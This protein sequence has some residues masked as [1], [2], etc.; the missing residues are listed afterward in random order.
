MTASLFHPFST[1]ALFAALLVC[2]L[3][4]QPLLA[5]QSKANAQDEPA[6]S[7]ESSDTQENADKENKNAGEADLDEAVIKRIDAKTIDQLESIGALLK[8]AISKGLD[9][10]NESFAKKMLASVLLERSQSLAASMIQARGRRALQLRDEIL[11][12]LDEAVEYDPTLVEAHL[13]IA[14]L[15]LL[16][17][18]DKQAI[19]EAT[20]NAIKL[21]KDDPIEMS[22]ALVLRAMTQDD[23]DK[24]LADLDAAIEADPNNMAAYQERAAMRLQQDD[25]E[26]AIEDLQI[27]LLKEPTNAEVAATVVQK[28]AELDRVDDAIE[29]ITKT[30]SSQPSEGLYRLRADL[31]RMEEKYDEALSDLNKAYAMQPED[32]RTLL[33]RAGLALERE[34]VKSAKQD[35]QSALRIQPAII[36]L[37]LAVALRAQIAMQENRLADAINDLKLLVERSPR[38]PFRRMQ[39]AN[40]YL[41]DK[42]PRKA[43]D[44]MSE[45]LD[46]DPKNMLALRSRGDTLLSVGDHAAAIE[47][48]EKALEIIGNL[49]LTDASPEQK[50]EAAAVYNNLSWV[51]STSPNDSVRDGQRAV[52]LGKK[53]AELSDFK[54]A[55]IL[56]T[57]AA[58]YAEVGNFDKAIEWSTKAV[59]LGREEEHAQLEQLEQELESYQQGKPWR[60]KQESEE[61]PVP[62]LSPEDLIDT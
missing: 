21:L 52:E 13:M 12:S 29:L 47:D 1:R 6:T 15:N 34:D 30:L 50:S 51:L 24:K 45:I 46:T 7:G 40:I 26:G 58:G 10:E 36:N 48:Y 60:E 37:D 42:R 19:V 35:F 11:D 55:H 4:P 32:Y 62:L 57:L 25:V 49:E 22:A 3:C 9:K 59:E 27:V 23:T 28:L 16:P 41:L 44:V 2:L 38:D 39:L 5:Q 56:S 20:T 18:G 17:G 33:Q 61:N 8:S 53:A 14:R 43:I 31:Y 54:E